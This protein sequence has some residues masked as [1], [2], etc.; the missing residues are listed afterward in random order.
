MT[1]AQ[2][3]DETVLSEYDAFIRE[4]V[5]GGMTTE[6]AE[7]AW[8]ALVRSYNAADKKQNQELTL[9]DQAIAAGEIEEKGAH[10]Q[11]IQTGSLYLLDS[12]G[13]GAGVK[14]MYTD[15]L[16]EAAGAAAYAQAVAKSEFYYQ[17]DADGKT[18][19]LEQARASIRAADQD[20]E[21]KELTNPVQLKLLTGEVA[22]QE[23]QRKE[24][25]FRIKTQGKEFALKYFGTIAETLGEK[26]LNSKEVVQLAQEL[27]I[28]LN[29]YREQGRFNDWVKTD[30]KRQ[31]QW[32][33]LQGILALDPGV[34]LGSKQR[35]YTLSASLGLNGQTIVEALAYNKTQGRKMDAAQLN[36]ITTS[37]WAQ[38]ENISMARDDQKRQWEQFEWSKSTWTQQ[39][40]REGKQWQAEFGLRERQFKYGISQDQ[41]G[42]SIRLLELAQSRENA[43]MNFNAQDRATIANYGATL[44]SSVA[45][46]RG[47]SQF[48][49]QT[50]AKLAAESSQVTIA[51]KNGSIYKTSDGTWVVKP[52]AKGVETQQYVDLMNRAT[53]QQRIGDVGAAELEGIRK[54]IL[55][56]VGDDA[57]IGELYSSIFGENTTRQPTPG[58][59][60]PGPQIKLTPEVRTSLINQAGANAPL[61]RTILD[62]LNNG[63]TDPATGQRVDD[64][65]WRCSQA[66]RLIAQ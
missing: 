44:R 26:G 51:L 15:K 4:K 37:T 1:R 39:F 62:T 59:A 48:A 49:A 28:N 18:L 10:A 34:A 31:T 21:F 8:G 57:G 25:V 27:G 16:G 2:S 5:E 9:R 52:G 65:D 33:E 50:A 32:K 40:N 35:I 53:E 41:V 36:Q 54:L 22:G 55:P 45:D 64:Q 19:S 23:L 43:L 66:L 20:Y 3:G 7:Q 56:G 61:V 58:P 63:L 24:L 30:Q 14:K 60:T 12:V 13:A 47:E 38:R 29:P 11:L 42:N 6:K 46:A 17:T